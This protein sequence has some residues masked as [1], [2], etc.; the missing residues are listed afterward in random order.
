VDARCT[1]AFEVS[2]IAC[3]ISRW[4]RFLR[5]EGLGLLRVS[6]EMDFDAICVNES[7]A[8]VRAEPMFDRKGRDVVVAVAKL[9][10]KIDTIGNA[11][12]AFKP[13]RFGASLD[14]HGAW[15]HPPEL[16]DDKP[17]T[18]VVLIG[19]A[20]PPAKKSVDRAL[21]WV[22][23]G[24]LRKV[25]TI[26]GPRRW[27][28]GMTG[29][30]AGPPAPFEEPVPLRF[31]HCY[32]GV[33]QG[34]SG[35]S[36]EPYNPAGRGYATDPK[37]L[38]GREMPCLEPVAEATRTNITPHKSHGCF[39]PIPETFEPRRSLAGTHDSTWAKKRAPIRPVDFNVAHNA[40]AMPELHS[41]TPLSSDT[42]FEVAGVTP[43]GVW[44]FKLPLYEMEFE[45]TILGEKAPHQSHLDSVLI[46]ADEHIVELSWR[47]SI[48]LPK[49]W[50]M[51]ERIVA[52]GLGTMP[53][54]VLET[55]KKKQAVERPSA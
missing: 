9:A 25:I 27:V 19:T 53:N 50:A 23:A 7:W 11:T 3:N 55:D 5:F 17:G 41:P 29:V 32:G 14:G 1:T 30:T 42:P 20:H 39:A 43:E 52:R 26:Y 21:A 38:V 22:Q 44:R 34:A 10:F 8:T 54:E 37:A 24:T 49:K 13:I 40:W 48:L 12:L 45:S 36:V 31:E 16:V 46:D 18:D 6:R 4:L 47:A 33:D 51:L 35:T 2:D 28:H 15:T